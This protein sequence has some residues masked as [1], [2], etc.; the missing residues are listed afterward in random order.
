[1]NTNSKPADF[2]RDAHEAKQS[3]VRRFGDAGSVAEMLKNYLM[4]KARQRTVQQA[5]AGSRFCA[6]ILDDGGVGVAHLCCDVCGEPPRQVSDWVPQPGTPAAETL[7]TLTVPDRASIGLATANA[8]ANRFVGDAASGDRVRNGRAEQWGD[9]VTEGDLLDV[10]DLKP[11]DRVGMVGCFSPLVERIRQRVQRLFI[12]EKGPRLTRDLLPEHRA[13]EVLP[14]CSVAL[15]TSTTIM[16]GTI[17][18][19]LLA[20]A[21]CREVVLLGPSTPLVPEFFV[22]STRHASLLSGVVVTDA[23]ELLNVVARGGGT[24][25]FK[26]CVVKVN[27]TVNA[28]SRF[29]R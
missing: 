23:E 6:V 25:A 11:D 24:R 8:L 20:T 27:V 22:E 14:E 7:A 1:M 28:S 2:G 4:A 16:N 18:A 12:F 29:L 5:V 10:L 17:D 21:D 19:L 26:T 3:P 9:A 13:P 15:I